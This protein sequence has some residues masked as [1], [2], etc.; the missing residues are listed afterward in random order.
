MNAYP[1]CLLVF[2]SRTM[3]IYVDPVSNWHNKSAEQPAYPLNGSKTSK[4]A[5]EIRLFDIIA[6]SGQKQRL[7]RITTNLR[8]IFRLVCRYLAL[9]RCC[10]SQK[11][12]YNPSAQI[13]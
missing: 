7:V 13:I 12:K 6:Q 2:L 1:R 3:R 10:F 8:V 11:K 4:L 5:L 9:A